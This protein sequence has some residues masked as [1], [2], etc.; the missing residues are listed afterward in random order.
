MDGNF[1]VV[2]RG[3]SRDEVDRAIAN[4]RREIIAA[5]TERNELAERIRAASSRQASPAAS[6]GSKAIDVSELHRRGQRLFDQVEHLKREA[7]R[8]REHQVQTFRVEVRYMEIYNEKA[9]D[10]LKRCTTIYV[11][12]CY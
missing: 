11:S 10:L 6:N 3:Y 1:P 5:T 9:Y 2:M 12:P 8:H 7:E 4:L